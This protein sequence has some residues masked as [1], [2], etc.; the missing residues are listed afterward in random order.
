MLHRRSYEPRARGGHRAQ[1]T[2]VSSIS[3]FMQIVCASQTESWVPLQARARNEP[4]VH[5]HSSG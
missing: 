4:C 1:R 3:E 5:R 2:L